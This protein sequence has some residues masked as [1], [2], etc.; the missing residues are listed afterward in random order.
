M[1]DPGHAWDQNPD[2]L[3]QKAP[4]DGKGGKQPREMAYEIY[5]EGDKA[6]LSSVMQQTRKKAS[7]VLKTITLNV[8][9]T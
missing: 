7:K 2:F 8:K 5:K 3:S 6:K 9:L 4:Q 1:V